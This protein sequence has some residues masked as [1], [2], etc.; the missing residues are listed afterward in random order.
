MA[1]APGPDPR[2]GERLYALVREL[3]PICRSI[4]G[5][6]VRR[7]LEILS[8]RLPLEV[9]EVP[10]GTPVL[11]WTVPPEWNIEDA[12]IADASGRRVVDF[13][14]SNLHVVGYSVPIRAR[15]SLAELRGHLFT[16]PDRPDWIPNRTSY[17]EESWGFCLSHRQ[18]E[19][20]P[21]GEYEVCI[22][23]RLEP[24]HLTY[25][26]LL[27]PGETDDEVLLCTHTCHPSLCDDNL[28][29][30]VVAAFLAE[31]L[32]AG[33]R[34][35]Y[36][37]RF[38]FA[39]GT[40]G[41]ITWLARNRERT[42]RIRHGLTLVCLGDRQPFTYKRTLDGRAA[43][44]EAVEQVLRERG[45]GHRVIDFHPYGHDER[46]FNSPGFRLAVGSLMRAQHGT[47][48]EY[49]TSAD[50]LD[51][52]TPQSLAESLEVCAAVL[53]VLQR[54][55]TYRSLQPYGEP[56]LGRRGLFRGLGGGTGIASMEMAML[57][58]LSLADGRHTLLQVA[59]RS[60]LPFATLAD[61]ADRL[62]EHQLLAKA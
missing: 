53:D 6:G 51:F 10:S 15:M 25:A 13:R 20:M 45:G 9:H 54:D 30:I 12:W 47:F 42:G 40:I 11:D 1:E 36:G 24:G 44:D 38:L 31:R 57:W 34:R 4:T 49:H 41:A 8:R 26:E 5:N 28:S 58:V 2:P 33:G 14:A 32:L 60:G 27:V 17:Y 21:E 39:P 7:T 59:A 29:G 50:D 61:A 37:V 19:A 16:L 3:Y 56:Q 35:R 18:L 55:A 48:P 52:V 43:I 22:D 46:Q 23:S 62:L